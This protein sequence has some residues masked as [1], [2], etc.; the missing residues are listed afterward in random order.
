M[1]TMP[2]CQVCEGVDFLHGHSPP[3]VHRDLKSHLGYFESK[4]IG[5]EAEHRPRQALQCEDL[6]LWP[7]PVRSVEDFECRV[8]KGLWKRRTS[9]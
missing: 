9:R 2:C 7:D 3:V 5:S 6:R 4:F 1:Y 8:P